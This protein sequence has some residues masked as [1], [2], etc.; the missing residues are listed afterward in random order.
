VVARGDYGA[1]L[2]GPRLVRPGPQEAAALA[3]VG[4]GAAALGHLAAA[5]AALLLEAMTLDEPGDPDTAGQRAIGSEE[6]DRVLFAALTGAAL[7]LLRQRT[8]YRLIDAALIWEAAGLLG[9]ASE[10]VPP[11]EPA[12]PGEP[13]TQ[14]ETR[15]LRYLPTH[16]SAREIATELCVS[17]HTVKTHLRHLYRKL[18]AHTRHEA[19]RRARAA[20]LLAASAGSRE[21]APPSVP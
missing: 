3:P 4:D 7:E 10:P 9:E 11:G 14:S 12:W 18:G 13:L 19:V 2:A 8:R 16:L 6:P 17:A 20:G 1:A 5:V 21:Q 15:V